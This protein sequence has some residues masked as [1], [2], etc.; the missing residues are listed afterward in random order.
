MVTNSPP[1]IFRCCTDT[2]VCWHRALFSTSGDSANRSLQLS[3]TVRHSNLGKSKTIPYWV[4]I[5]ST[6]RWR[7]EMRALSNALFRSIL[8]TLRTGKHFRLFHIP[9]L[10]CE[11]RCIL[12]LSL[13]CVWQSHIH[14]CTQRVG[15]A[16]DL[17][18]NRIR[19]VSRPQRASGRIGG[20][21]AGRR[22]TP[23]VCPFG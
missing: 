5:A 3:R 11:Y 17:H 18:M 20:V 15:L 8:N 22:P 16:R 9:R 7:N 10:F 23:P 13:L 12:H 6:E 2:T 19:D 14:P 1:P 4:Y 21:T